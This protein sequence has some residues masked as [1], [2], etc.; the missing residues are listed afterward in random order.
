MLLF[1]WISLKSVGSLIALLFLAGCTISP[2]YSDR[3]TTSNS[4]NLAFASPNSRLEQIVYSQLVARF[5]RSLSPDALLVTV[6][7]T[8]SSIAPGASSVGLKGAISV[9]GP[10]GETIFNG[11]RSA[12]ASY[13]GSGQSLANQQAAN[14]A[15]E[16]AALQLA[17]T[18]RLTLIGVLS[19]RASK[20]AQQTALQ[21]NQAFAGQ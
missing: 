8:P 15:A 6:G 4:F 7:V 2:V 5:G 10:S 14:E 17:E 1:K 13:A 12:S 9:T 19:A 16:R 20:T 3:S 18:I 21:T 11:T